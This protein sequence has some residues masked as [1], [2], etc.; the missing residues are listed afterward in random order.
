MELVG[1]LSN[2]RLAPLRESARPVGLQVCLSSMEQRELF[3]DSGVQIASFL[4]QCEKP[5]GLAKPVR[6]LVRSRPRRPGN[7]A[8][9]LKLAEALRQR[10]SVNAQ[11]LANLRVRRFPGPANWIL[12]QAQEMFDDR[13]PRGMAKRREQKIHPA[14]TVP[15]VSKVETGSSKAKLALARPKA[16]AR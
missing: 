1:R 15:F 5:I 3:P 6:R 4:E 2:P 13:E 7:K 8:S 14:H 12:V 10:A 11:T 16:G 9:L